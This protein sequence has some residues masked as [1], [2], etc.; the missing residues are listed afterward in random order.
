[1]AGDFCI[2]VSFFKNGLFLWSVRTDNFE[3]DVEDFDSIKVELVTDDD[4]SSEEEGESCMGDSDED[5]L[6]PDNVQAP[7]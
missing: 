1:M 2:K 6:T 3:F 5:N 7:K 4:Y